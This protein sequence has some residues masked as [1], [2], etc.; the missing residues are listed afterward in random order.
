MNIFLY[1][2]KNFNRD[3][4]LQTIFTK[5]FFHLIKRHFGL[6]FNFAEFFLDKTTLLAMRTNTTNEN[7]SHSLSQFIHNPSIC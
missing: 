3:G 4:T 1:N 7:F 5:F 2:L 6:D